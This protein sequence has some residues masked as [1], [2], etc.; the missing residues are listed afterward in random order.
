MPTSKGWCTGTSSPPIS[1]STP[2]KYLGKRASERYTTAKDMGDDLRYWLDGGESQ[3]SLRVEIVKQPD[4][5]V[6][7]VLPPQ[8]TT[9]PGPTDTPMSPTPSDSEKPVKIVPKGLRY[10]DA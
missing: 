7:L 9:T 6:H 5:N 10:F 2:L 1:L 4:I 3:A 8:A